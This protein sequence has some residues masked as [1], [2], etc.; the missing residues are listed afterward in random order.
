MKRRA[1]QMQSCGN[2]WIGPGLKIQV[3]DL[4]HR[5]AEADRYVGRRGNCRK[6]DV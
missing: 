1:V 6:I 5:I 4:L 3:R 2:D